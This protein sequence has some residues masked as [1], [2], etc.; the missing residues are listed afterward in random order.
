MEMRLCVSTFNDE[1]YLFVVIAESL[2]VRPSAGA[3]AN[4]YDTFQQ[5]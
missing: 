4:L 5:S 1:R 2:A 3:R